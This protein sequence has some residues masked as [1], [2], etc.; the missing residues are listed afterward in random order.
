[1]GAGT[2]LLDDP[3]LHVHWEELGRTAG[4]PPT[5][6]VLDAHG[7]IPD[8]ARIFDGSAPTLVA[9]IVEN[10][11]H[12]PPHVER[13][14]V[15]GHDRVDFAALWA[16]LYARGMRRV[17]VEGGARVLQSLFASGLFDRLTVFVAPVAIGAEAAPPMVA[18][19]AARSFAEAYAFALLGIERIDQGFVASYAP[20]PP[21]P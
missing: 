18:G 11:R 10:S 2:V 21:P 8:T 17:L 5:R 6:I 4:P 9:T 7:Q 20:G 13:V 3:S 15:A 19:P 14:V 1:M 12:Y 16:E